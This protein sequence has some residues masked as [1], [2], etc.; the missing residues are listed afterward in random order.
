MLDVL[1]AFQTQPEPID[2]VLPGLVAGSVGAI[3]SPG[4]AGKSMMALQIAS[5]IAG[6]PD[7]LGLGELKT[8]KVMYLPAEDPEVTIRHRLHALGQHLDPIQ[9]KA[10]ADQLMVEPLIGAEPNVLRPDWT[11]FLMGVGSMSRLI[12]LDTL[13]R[14]HLAD[15][16]DSGAMSALIGRLEH[17]TKETGT[18][19]VFLH[20]ASKAAA[21]GGQGDQQQASRGSS[22]LVDNIRWQAYLAGMTKDEAPK[23]SARPADAK[24]LDEAERHYYVR[25][26]VSK[27]NYGPPAGEK[28]LRRHEGGVLKLADIRPA[29]RGGAGKKDKPADPP[30]QPSQ[31]GVNN[32][33]W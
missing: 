31:R 4:G 5:Q 11:D 21:L 12:V 9:R 23:L 32:G 28:W 6:G 7:M 10:V 13:R 3:V 8:G 25:W 15:E 2:Y 14:F 17:I 26:G 27:Q 22:V 30:A 18:T 24:P 19:I 20:H 33:N 16:N 29:S 1:K